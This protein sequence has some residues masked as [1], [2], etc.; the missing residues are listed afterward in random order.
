MTVLNRARDLWRRLVVWAMTPVT[1]VWDI[2]TVMFFAFLSL[3]FLT[4]HQPEFAFAA[5][6]VA[7]LPE[8]LEKDE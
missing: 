1:P 8:E 7:V 2:P 5:F 3:F 6:V 4:L